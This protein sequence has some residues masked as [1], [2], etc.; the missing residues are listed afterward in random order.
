MGVTAA[1][2]GCVDWEAAFIG[3]PSTNPV[4]IPRSERHSRSESARSRTARRLGETGYMALTALPAQT[5]V[6]SQVHAAA[7]AGHELVALVEH[8]VNAGG[9]RGR[10]SARSSPRSGTTAAP[11][12]RD[13]S[14]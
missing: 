10:S 4:L 3:L 6:L 11:R 14:P 13:R 1:C 12:W 7:G 8:G 2:A 9:G 5:C